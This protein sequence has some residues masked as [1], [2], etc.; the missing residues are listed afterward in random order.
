MLTVV[1]VCHDVYR[2]VGRSQLQLWSYVDR[3]GCEIWAHLAHGPFPRGFTMSGAGSEMREC[4]QDGG[5]SHRWA[6]G[7]GD[8]INYRP[9]ER[10]KRKQG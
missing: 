2:C 5:F 1:V 4:E 6:C 3:L 8:I 7:L 9:Y 10:R